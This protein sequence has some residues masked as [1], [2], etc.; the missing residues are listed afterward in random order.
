M[1]HLIIVFIL[2][3]NIVFAQ[4]RLILNGAYINIT[5]GANLVVD[6]SATNAITTNSGHIISEG[7]NNNIKWNIGTTSGTYTVPLGYN[8]TNYIPLIF[9]K[10]AGSGTGTFVFST[11]KTSNWQNSLSLPT[12]VPDVNNASGADNSANVIDRFWK[13]NVSGYATKPD[14]SSLIFT[15][16]DAEHTVASNTITEANLI[17]QRYNSSIPNWGDYLPS[18]TVNTTLNQ[19]TVS[20]LAAANMF[21]WWTL[22]VTN[23]PLPIELISFTAILKNNKTVDL[24][25][26]T[27]SELNNDYY[28]IEKSFD[29]YNWSYLTKVKGAGTTNIKQEYIAND[30]E[31]YIGITY[32]RLKQVDYNSTFSFSN[33]ESVELNVNGNIVVK[34]NPF[35]YTCELQLEGFL[36]LKKLEV[37]NSIGQVVKSISIE[38]SEQKIIHLDFTNIATGVY[39]L[40]ADGVALSQKLI[41]Q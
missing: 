19:V 36:N 16:I 18:S 37:F 5:N 7:E 28:I 32:Y 35:T 24:K 25:W 30:P 40:R 1:K 17:A 31:P 12:G 33:I 14:F 13:I 15:Y 26:A 11:Y 39:Y 22:S 3:V 2:L 41:K 23:S 27:A 4:N 20:G 38:S 6:N 34:P 10:S 9:T 29:G 8:T 21:D